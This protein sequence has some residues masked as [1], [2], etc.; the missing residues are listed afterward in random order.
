MGKKELYDLLKP[1]IRKAVKLEPEADGS[2]LL[3]S[4]ESK[5]GGMPYAET[6]DVWPSC[7]TCKKELT[8]VDQIYH[9]DELQL[10]VFYYCNECFPWGLGDEEKG[11]WLVKLYKKPVAGKMVAINRG[12]DDEFAPRP[13][14][15]V[16]SSVEVLPDWEG[17]ESASEEISDLC[18]KINDDAPWEEDED[19][20]RRFAA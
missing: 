13:C 20:V 15:V 10:F 6:G 9:E 12:A 17:L 7:P 11:Q 2:A 4:C 14:R 18:C 8:F 5:F 16:S 19:A 3:A 1:L